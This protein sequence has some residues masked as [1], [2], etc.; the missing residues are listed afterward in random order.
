MTRGTDKVCLNFNCQ[1]KKCGNCQEETEIIH[2]G[3]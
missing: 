3:D 2:P 1:E